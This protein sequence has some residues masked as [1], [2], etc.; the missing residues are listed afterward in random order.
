MRNFLSC[1]LVSALYLT[2]AFPVKA[3]CYFQTSRYWAVTSP[4][5]FDENISHDEFIALEDANGRFIDGVVANDELYRLRDEHP[6]ELI[7]KTE[8]Y[9]RM[10]LPLRDADQ[11]YFYVSPFSSSPEFFES[12]MYIRF[13]CSWAPKCTFEY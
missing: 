3:E 6:G 10:L 13:E 11:G 9:C 2:H 1:L 8:N 5:D 12:I 4:F 7:K